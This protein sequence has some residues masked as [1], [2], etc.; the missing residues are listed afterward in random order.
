MDGSAPADQPTADADQDVKPDPALP[1]FRISVVERQSATGG[2]PSAYASVGSGSPFGAGPLESMRVGD[3]RFVEA[4]VPVPCEP[5]C[6][7]SARCSPDGQCVE[8]QK[9]L[10]AGPVTIEGLK[11]QT[12]IEPEYPEGGQYF[13]YL[14]HF[15]PEPENGDLFD[16][17]D[18]LTARASGGTTRFE[19]EMAVPGFEVQTTGTAPLQSQTPCPLD[20][21]AEQDLVVSWQPEAGTHRITFVLYSANHGAQFSRIECET[22]DTGSLVVDRTLV[23]SWLGGFHPVRAWMLQRSR[24]AIGVGGTVTVSFLVANNLSCT[25]F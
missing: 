17:G 4:H 22:D 5:A 23:A 18:P 15:D 8:R 11:V 13:Y 24:E 12:T 2:D 16:A 1:R 7:S 19:H 14:P 3:C 10:H 6:P 9:R 25:W 20:L 21:S